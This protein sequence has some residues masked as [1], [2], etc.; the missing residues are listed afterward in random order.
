[1]ANWIYGTILKKSIRYG[2]GNQNG[3]KLA[4]DISFMESLKAHKKEYGVKR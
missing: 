4:D 2:R 3:K 1:M